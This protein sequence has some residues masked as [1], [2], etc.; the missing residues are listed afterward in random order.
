MNHV[1]NFEDDNENWD[2]VIQPKTSLFTLNLK[3][4][5]RYRDLVWLF[6]K[7]DFVAQF[8]QTI[9][10]PAWHFVQPVLTTIMFTIVF[11]RIA[12]I[13]TGDD[14]PQVLFYMSGIT[15]WNYFAACLNNTASTFIM[16]SDIFG[17]VYFPRLVLPISV[18]IS[19]VV[20]FAIQL[21]LLF[22]VMVYYS[23]NGFPI[24]IGWNL[25]LIPVLVFMMA[26]LGLGSGIII[27][28]L[29]TKYRDFNVLVGFAVQLLM[30]VTPVVLPMT[31]YLNSKYK[32]IITLNPLSAVVETFRYAI[33]NTG[34]FHLGDLAYSFG[35]LLIILLIGIMVFNKVEKSFMDT[36]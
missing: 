30:Y 6:V 7:R 21:L 28:A 26:M 27:S 9:M 22:S 3:D 15:I 34:K 10:G 18:V 29:T 25:L 16:N 35:F 17:K 33:F 5:W 4:V 11:G 36:V 31:Y 2:L 1:K 14:I 12:K 20:K 8:K 13:Q 24:H 23:F 19:N 32:L